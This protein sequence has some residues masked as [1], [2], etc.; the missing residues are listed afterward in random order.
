MKQNYDFD[1]TKIKNLSMEEKTSRQKNLDLF[2]KSGFPS[3]QIEDWKFTDLNLILNKNFEKISNKVDFESNEELEIIKNF[4]H[5]YILLNNGKIISTSF[6]YEEKNKILIKD[7]E[8]KESINLEPNNTLALLNNALSSGGF[9]LEINKNYKLKKPL[10][11]YN[12]FSKDLK[13][14]ILNNKNSIKLNEGSEL[15]LIDYNEGNI[16]NNFIKN[17]I[18]TVSLDTNAV[19]KNIFIQESKC[20]GHF[21]KYIQGSLEGGSN[22]E[23]YILS[24]GLKLNKIEIEINLNRDNSSCSIYSALNLLESQ[25]QEIK[26][27]INHNSPNCKSYQKIKNVLNDKS[28]GVYQGKIFV[29]KI[30]QKTDAYQLSKALILNDDA[31]FDA[32]PELEIYAD[33]VKCSHGSTSGSIDPDAVYYLMTRGISKK[34]AVKLLISGFLNEML[35]NI[36]TTPVKIFLKKILERQINGH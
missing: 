9:S 33:D 26:T 36:T 20:N 12:Y 24:S 32:K 34:E 2:Y 35:E 30:A 16:Q 19:L 23:N 21:Y 17:T 7:F 14:K 25:H 18:E 28:R 6:A 15:T 11:I 29:N 5:N 3:K 13:N 22:Y 1:I 31:E 27:R 4:E 10:V 8:Q